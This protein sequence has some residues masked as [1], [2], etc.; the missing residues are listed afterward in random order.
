MNIIFLLKEI[1]DKKKFYSKYPVCFTGMFL[2]MFFSC[3]L[4]HFLKHGKTFFRS[5]DGLDQHYLIFVYIG[6]LLRDFLAIY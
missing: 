6:K 4:I 5:Y 1:V 3:F 2:F